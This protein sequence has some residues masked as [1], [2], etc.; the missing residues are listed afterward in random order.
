MTGSHNRPYHIPRLRRLEISNPAGF[1]HDSRLYGLATTVGVLRT[2]DATLREVLDPGL[3]E[4]VRPGG[5]RDGTLT[6]LFDSAAWMTRFRYQK[7]GVE[8]RLRA[9]AGLEQLREIRCKVAPPSRY[10]LPKTRPARKIARKSA[11]IIYKNAEGFTDPELREAL[12]RL[13][14]SIGSDAES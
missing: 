6:L 11:Q 3:G 12:Q 7:S 4:H 13:A 10:A 5:Y 1:S 2:L 14:G 9:C 8:A